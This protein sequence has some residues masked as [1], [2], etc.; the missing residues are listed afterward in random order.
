M[1]AS[2]DGPEGIG[3]PVWSLAERVRSGDR[4]A[5]ARALTLVEG[6]EAGAEVVRPLLAGMVRAH[7]VGVTG[8]PGAG[9]STLVGR[10]A[11]RFREH[12]RRVG[13]LAVDPTS[14]FSGGALLGDRLRMELPAGDPDVFMRSLASRGHQ[15]GL[16]RAVFGMVR[17]LDAAG[18]DVILVET[19]GAGQN[20]VGVLGVADTVV[21]ALNPAA[22]D[23]IQA[24]KAGIVEIA[25]IAV[26]HKADLPGAA[27][28]Y[29]AVAS[30]LDVPDTV[31]AGRDEDGR[32]KT[33]VLLVS[34]AT[35]QGIG[36]LADTITSHAR[37]L[38]STAD[39]E[40][41]RRRQA[42]WELRAALAAS[43][44]QR[45]VGP[46]RASGLWDELARQV[47]TGALSAA[48]AARR[49]TEDLVRLVSSP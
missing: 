49:L 13:I 5:L 22:G 4:A 6:L 37:H 45:I 9:K 23:E 12:G 3:A 20:D 24:L 27:E 18:M 35:G 40:R 47:A 36:E 26:V 7:V 11:R 31:G 16:A 38:L 41:R 34:S 2:A 32:W 46:A 10:L 21:L 39:G 30:A 19:V 48:D 42:E 17:L 25:D 28:T 33:R 14:P 29:R 1:V 43:M 8:S 15:G 44:E